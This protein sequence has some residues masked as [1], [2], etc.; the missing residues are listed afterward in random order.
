MGQR[1]GW[2]I[3]IFFTWLLLNFLI[4]TFSNLF[5][6]KKN[7]M[8]TC[9]YTHYPSVTI[10]SILLMFPVHFLTTFCQDLNLNYKIATRKSFKN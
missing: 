8:T 7:S 5:K 4:W 1:L 3:Y 6:G 9:P 2:N 10:I